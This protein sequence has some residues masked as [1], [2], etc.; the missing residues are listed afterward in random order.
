[1]TSLNVFVFFLKHLFHSGINETERSGRNF[2]LNSEL[3]DDNDNNDDN[4]DD[5][6]VNDNNDNDDYDDDVDEDLGIIALFKNFDKNSL[7][8]SNES[9]LDLND[10]SDNDDDDER[11]LD[12]VVAERDEVT[13]DID[14]GEAETDDDYDDINDTDVDGT[15]DTDDAAD[16]DDVDDVD[17]EARP[18]EFP[19]ADDISNRLQS[20]IETL[21][22]FASVNNDTGVSTDTNTNTN[23][24]TDTNTEIETGDII[25][26]N[27]TSSSLDSIS[28]GRLFFFLSKPSLE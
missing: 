22:S 26:R 1:M 12:V 13:D 11:E 3:G 10:V 25:T 4:D 24:D 8:V 2:D 20:W 23:A 17:D 14:G 15:N 18:R 28:P 6:D 16:A 7:K 5:D 9:T 27:G 19:T 21:K